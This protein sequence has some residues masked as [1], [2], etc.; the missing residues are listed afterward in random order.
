MVGHVPVL[1]ILMIVQGGL[2]AVAGLLLLVAAVMAPMLLR[3]AEGPPPPEN[4]F[5]VI[6][7]VYGVMAA[8]AIIAAVLHILGGVWAYRFRKRTVGIVALAVGIAS[9]FTCYCAPTSIALAIYG[10]IVLLN[11]RVAQA[12]AMGDDGISREDVLAAFRA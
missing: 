2:E 1:A 7:I 11:P 10:L 5:W 12:F 3:N 8:A 6:G 4:M 9:T